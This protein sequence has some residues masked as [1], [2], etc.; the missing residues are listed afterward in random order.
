MACIASAACPLSS[1]VRA[2]VIFGLVTSRD[3]GDRSFDE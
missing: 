1:M 3:E 2:C